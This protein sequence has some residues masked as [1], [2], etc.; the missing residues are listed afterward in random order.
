MSLTRTQK[1]TMSAMLSALSIVYL[2]FI[3]TIDLGVWSFTPFS[4]IFIFIGCLISPYTGIMTYITTLASFMLKSGNYF[5][6]LR[7]ASHIFFVVFLLF[8]AKF[9]GI[10]TKKDIAITFVG[11]SIIHTLFE[12]G[13]VLLGL[14]VGMSG[15]NS[16]AY[17]LLFVLGVGN[18]L[19]NC[20]DYG[21]A[22]ALYKKSL[23]P[24]LERIGKGTKNL[25]E[26]NIVEND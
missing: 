10:K 22:L 15:V 1:I 14:A 25:T 11:T 3:P 9:R 20:L 26:Y 4:H 13:A 21:V 19:H 8:Y 7:A 6:W 24:V 12:L 5:V 23:L 18:I 16:T 17:Y 2:Y